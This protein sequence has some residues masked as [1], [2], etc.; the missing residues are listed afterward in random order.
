MLKKFVYDWNPNCSWS[1]SWFAW[2]NLVRSSVWICLNSSFSFAKSAFI[3][4]SSSNFGSFWTCLTIPNFFNREISSWIMALSSS[5]VSIIFSS[6]L[7]CA[8]ACTFCLKT[9]SRSSSR[10]WLSSRSLASSLCEFWHSASWLYKSS[11]KWFPNIISKK[12]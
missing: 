8:S 12:N 7:A 11:L 1:T 5:N 10:I 2:F 9:S 4:S 6:S 3:S